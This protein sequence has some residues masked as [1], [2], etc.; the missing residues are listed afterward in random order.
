MRIRRSS[1]ILLASLACCTA[2]GDVKP[3]HI[4]GGGSDASATV[5]RTNLPVSRD[6]RIDASDYAFRGLPVHAPSGWLTLRL[7]NAGKETHMLAIAPVPSG[8]TTSGFV[9]SLVHLHLAPNTTF[10]PGVDVV[11]PGDTAVTTSFFPAGAYAVACFVK[12]EDGA[13]HV[14][15]GMVG[16]FDVV[17]AW[18]TGVAP[19][20]ASVVTLTGN[21]IG[22]HG[23]SM[24][25]GVHTLR[26]ESSNPHPQDFQILKLLPG[27]SATD[28][29]RWFTHRTT[30]AP[31]AEALGGVSSIHSGQHA[32]VTVS[33]TPG[34][35]LLFY[36]VDEAD[37]HPVF[38]QRTLAIPPMLGSPLD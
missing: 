30:L 7:V 1:H 37:P 24:R 35:Y 4:A 31:A 28:A 22:L 14:V 9:D 8:Y 38:V 27:R 20:A 33:F 23:D 13:L 5:S 18:D 10:W 17:P 36:V 26:I 19:T 34:V 21:H 3:L 11:S 32:S 16:S 29:L 6:Y 15:K 12:S 25:S 2:S